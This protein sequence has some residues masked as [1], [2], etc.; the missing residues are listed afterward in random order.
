MKRMWIALVL[1]ACSGAPWAF[2]Q[3]DAIPRVEDIS[4]QIARYIGSRE[5][6]IAQLER[7]IWLGLYRLAPWLWEPPVPFDPY[8]ELAAEFDILLVEVIVSDEDLQIDPNSQQTEQEEEFW[9]WILPVSATL[10]PP[11]PG[12]LLGGTPSYQQ[13]P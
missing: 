3:G 12:P 5:F 7:G 4:L 13:F 1:L 9:L 10:G 11:E 6:G 8:T 2:G